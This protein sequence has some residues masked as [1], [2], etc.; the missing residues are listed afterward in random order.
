LSGTISQRGA[1]H[2]LGSFSSYV[3][4]QTELEEHLSL[5][6]DSHCSP[7]LPAGEVQT[8][9]SSLFDEGNSNLVTLAN[10]VWR[11]PNPLTRVEK[12]VLWV[13]I[14]Y[15]DWKEWQCF[16]SWETIARCAGYSKKKIGDTLG[17]LKA[18][19]L[20]SWKRRPFNSNFYTVHTEVIT[21]LGDS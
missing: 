19:G 5:L 10:C 14:V 18:D 8:T 15:C 7:P 20:I 4:T 6:N 17:A 12:A 9:A 21:S 11:Y 2:G 16:P 3:T 13:L 1:W